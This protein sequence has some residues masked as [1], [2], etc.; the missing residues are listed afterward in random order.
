MPIEIIAEQKNIILHPTESWKK[1]RIKSSEL[2]VNRNYYVKK[3][4]K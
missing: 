1:I 4:E 3:K 2:E